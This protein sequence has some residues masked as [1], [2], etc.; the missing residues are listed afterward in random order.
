MVGKQFGKLTVVKR[1]ERPKGH[2]KKIYWLCQC[3]C[4]GSIEVRGD[5]LRRAL[6]NSCGCL[7]TG[8]EEIHGLSLVDGKETS[9][10]LSYA[11]AKKN[12]GPNSK[13][14][15][16]RGIKFKFESFVDFLRHIGR[17]PAGTYLARI[18]KN[19]D[20]EIGNI[21]WKFYKE[22]PRNAITNEIRIASPRELSLTPAL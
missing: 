20:W 7:P 12:C 18:E 19:G 5:H 2:G 17:K 21:E 15:S 9:E 10:F 3:E 11:S 22:V 6:I 16:Y 8:V 4:A 13:H 14:A 1:A